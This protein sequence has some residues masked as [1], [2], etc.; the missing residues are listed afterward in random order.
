M[1]NG[2]RIQVIPGARSW[3]IVTM[4]FVE[5]S[6]DEVIKKIMPISH[7]VC[8]IVAMIESGAYEVHP[9]FAAPPGRKK[10]ASM[11]TPPTK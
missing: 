7:A 1:K 4:M 6:S 3:K 5:P 11:T 10:L 9:E 2:N 8:P